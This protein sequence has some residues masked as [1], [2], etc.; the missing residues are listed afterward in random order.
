MSNPH[1]R[2]RVLKAMP[3]ARPVESSRSP[4]QESKSELGKDATGSP[5]GVLTFAAN[6]SGN[7]SEMPRACPVAHRWKHGG[8]L[9]PRLEFGHR[10]ILEYSTSP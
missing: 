5:R 6:G 9:S 7:R 3:R 10:L 8:D 1:L 4:L 2:D